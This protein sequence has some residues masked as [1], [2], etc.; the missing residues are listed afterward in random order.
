MGWCQFKV[1]PG[2]V[3]TTDEVKVV[4]LKFKVSEVCEE[5]RLN[6]IIGRRC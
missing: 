5:S 1:E 3:V 2:I 6:K 4:E